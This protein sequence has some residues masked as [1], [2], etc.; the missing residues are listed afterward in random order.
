MNPV[1][2]AVVTT[3]PRRIE[4]ANSFELMGNENLLNSWEIEDKRCACGESHNVTLTDARL[5]LRS[6]DMNCC[7]CCDS[8]HTDSSIFLRDIAEMR[9]STTGDDRCSWCCI[10]RC[11]CCSCCCSISKL[12]EIRGIFGSK[13]LHVKK[14]DLPKVQVEI[15]AAIGNHKLVSQY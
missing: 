3:Q 1:R 8:D 10:Q 13:Y 11:P 5:L 14:E 9:E 6:E 4:I 12:I 7:G 2:S 15:P